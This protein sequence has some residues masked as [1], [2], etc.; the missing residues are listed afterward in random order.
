MLS[1]KKSQ[2]FSVLY[3]HFKI[4]DVPFVVFQDSLHKKL[5]INVPLLSDSLVGRVILGKKIDMLS[6]KKSQRFSVLYLNLINLCLLIITR[7]YN[8]TVEII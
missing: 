4:P 3:L 6:Y 2:R 7:K 8:F 5:S 1:Y